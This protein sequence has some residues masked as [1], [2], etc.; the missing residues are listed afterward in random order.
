M[1]KVFSSIIALLGIGLVAI[2]TGIIS[3]AYVQAL[4]DQKKDSER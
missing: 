4:E 3:G 1:G 2:P